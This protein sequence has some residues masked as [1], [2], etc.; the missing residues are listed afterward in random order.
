[1]LHS[2]TRSTLE[3]NVGRSRTFNLLQFDTVPFI[4]FCCS[5]IG[6]LVVL[7]TSN[8]RN[9]SHRRRTQELRARLRCLQRF[10]G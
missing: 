5:D 7:T 3:V 2:I 1:M 8:S 4:K 6:S 10:Q 9:R